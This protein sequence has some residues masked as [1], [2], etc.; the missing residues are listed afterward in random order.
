MKFNLEKIF[1]TFITI[2]AIGVGVLL[3]TTVG[4]FAYA[5]IKSVFNL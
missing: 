4:I 2:F 5:I 1:E 3:M